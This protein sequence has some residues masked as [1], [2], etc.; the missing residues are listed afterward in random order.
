[1]EE[2]VSPGDV[3]IWAAPTGIDNEDTEDVMVE[4]V[5]LLPCGNWVVKEVDTGECSSV[6]PENLT[7]ILWEGD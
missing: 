2:E 7:R 3:A 4:L 5:R 6:E 1:M